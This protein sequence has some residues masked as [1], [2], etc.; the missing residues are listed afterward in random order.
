[1]FGALASSKTN[2]SQRFDSELLPDSAPAERYDAL[3]VTTF[4]SIDPRQQQTAVSC[5]GAMVLNNV[6]ITH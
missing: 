2:V 6:I 3:K 1:M 4:A 5:T